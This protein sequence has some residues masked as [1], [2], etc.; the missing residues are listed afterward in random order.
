[1][2]EPDPM[3][4][5][6]LD[7]QSMLKRKSSRDPSS[8]FSA[9]LHILLSFVTAHPEME[10]KVGCAWVTEEEFRLNKRVLVQVMGIKINTLNVNLHA[11]GFNQQ[12]HNKDGW[13][14]WKKPGFTRTSQD[15]TDQPHMASVKAGA[16]APRNFQL[17]ITLGPIQNQEFETFVQICKNIWTELLTS[18]DRP[19]QTPHFID[20]AAQRFK[21]EEQPLDNARDVLRAIIAPSPNQNV[22]TFAQFCKFMAMFG[23]EK[24]IM[25]KIA[26]LL[27]SSNNSG[28][29][30][31]FEPQTMNANT[32]YG[33]FSDNEPNCLVLNYRNKPVRIWNLPNVEAM[34]NKRYIVDEENR[35]YSSWEEYF[36]YNPVAQQPEYTPA[37]SFS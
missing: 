3:N 14:L 2:T 21:Q 37:Y 27:S 4:I 19:V 28:Q 25:L 26:S 9:K 30:L 20:V 17:N 16:M 13:T 22:V 31:M 23:P 29:W 34:P 10:D 24:T 35:Y 7:I 33:A 36:Q 15:F 1:M 11:L 18:D 8:R 12:K 32:F 6:P 5:L